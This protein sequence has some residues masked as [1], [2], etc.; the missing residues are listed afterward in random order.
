MK[1]YADFSE[2]PSELNRALQVAGI[3]AINIPVKR[4]TYDKGDKSVER[5]KNAADM[6]LALDAVLEAI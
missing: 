3:E 4:T 6:V 5:V 1:A 2:H